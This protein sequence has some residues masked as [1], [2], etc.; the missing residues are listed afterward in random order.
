D[1]RHAVRRAV[2]LLAVLAEGRQA[3]ARHGRSG[4]LRRAVLPWTATVR[5]WTWSSTFV[6]R[7]ATVVCGGGIRILRAARDDR[8]G[9]NGAEAQHLDQDRTFEVTH[10]TPK[11]IGR[12]LQA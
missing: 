8:R 4:V 11:G 7:P 1:L 6:G 5:A 3:A 2:A 12:N 9:R 10:Q